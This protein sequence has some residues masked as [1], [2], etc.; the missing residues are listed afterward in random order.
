MIYSTKKKENNLE[1][2]FK[3]FE[4]I[5]SHKKCH[6]YP[7]L[8]ATNNVKSTVTNARGKKDNLPYCVLK[9]VIQ[10]VRIFYYLRSINIHTHKNE[11]FEY[12]NQIVMYFIQ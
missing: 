5:E 6:I 4:A 8:K 10:S 11:Y 3:L 7:I 12:Q 9:S 2:N 1:M